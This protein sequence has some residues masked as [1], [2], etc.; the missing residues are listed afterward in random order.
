M[1]LYTDNDEFCCAWLRELVKQ[2][3]IPQ[4]DVLC[5]SITDIHPDE[6]KPYHSVHFFCGIGGWPLALRLAGWPDDEP[7]DTGSCPCQPLSEAGDGLGELDPRHLWPQFHRL[8]SQRRPAT[9]FGEQVA[10][11]DGLEWLDG[12]SLDLEELGYAVAAC[13]LPAASVGLNHKR[14]RIFFSAYADG[15]GRKGLRLRAQPARE[16]RQGGAYSKMALLAHDPFRS[17]PGWPQP[18]V[19]VLDDGLPGDVELLRGYGNAIAPEAGATFIQAAEAARL[20]LWARAGGRVGRLNAQVE[21]DF[22]G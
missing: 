20:D 13:D 18:L 9:V 1:I 10:S 17:G 8:I 6:L 15:D 5:K 4:G 2:N 22:W 11:E 3:Q 19:R 14:Q 21:E 7:V 12:V 16:A